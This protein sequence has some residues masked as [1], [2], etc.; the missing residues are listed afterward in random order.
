MLTRC[1]NMSLPAA[2]NGDGQD[3]SSHADND[4]VD[5]SK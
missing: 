2:M 4:T 1:S 5:V 3:F